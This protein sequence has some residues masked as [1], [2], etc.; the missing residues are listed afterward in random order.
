MMEEEEDSNEDDDEDDFDIDELDD[1]G[2]GNEDAQKQNQLMLSLVDMWIKTPPIT[3]IYVGTS[4]SL[5][6]AAFLFN[7]NQWPEVLNLDWKSVLGL[8]VW[9][10]FTAFLFFGPLGFNYLLTIHFVW[11]YMAQLEKLNYKNPED[12]LT[13]L[14]FGGAA[15]M[16]GY[17][18]LGLSPK[19]LGHNLSTFLVYI[20]ARVF[21][22]TD[23]NVMDLF[24][25][26]AEYLPWFFCLQTAVLEGEMPFA[27]I[28]GI[29]VG[30][31]YQYLT[32]QRILTTPG[33]VR[34]YFTSDNIKKKYMAYKDDFE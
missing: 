17:T 28:L 12:F 2:V 22:G 25:L 6:L 7:K 23:V 27:D 29:V 1:E 34:N 31:L 24:N 8:Q 32:Q 20:W 33:I 11:T 19:F 5:T 15:L 13:M 3:Q 4:I 30:H 21:E 16:V 10:V 18:V 9:R 14:V 26:K